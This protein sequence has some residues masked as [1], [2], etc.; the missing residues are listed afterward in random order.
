MSIKLSASDT[1]SI[2][3]HGVL[4]VTS[5]DLSEYS[6]TGEILSLSFTD[7][8]YKDCLG[9]TARVTGFQIINDLP[10]HI[11]VPTAIPYTEE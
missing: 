5:T 9:C 7:G 3:T 11:V 8:A 2:Q 6:I 10:Y 1:L 4:A